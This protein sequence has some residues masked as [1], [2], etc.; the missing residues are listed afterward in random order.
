MNELIISALYTYPIKSCHGISLTSTKIEARGLLH[1]RRWMLIDQNNR[2]ISQRE[3]A[4]LSRFLLNINDHSLIVT[5]NEEQKI[6][7][8]LS[9]EEINSNSGELVKIWDDTCP[10]IAYNEDINNWF[11]Q[12]IGKPCRL[13]YMPDSSM[14]QVDL[15]YASAGQI[16]AFSDGYPILILGQESMNNLNSLLSTPIS[17]NRFRPNIVFT[18][19]FPHVED[20]FQKIRINN[21][22]LECVKPSRRCNVPNINQETSI[23]GDEPTKTLAGYRLFDKRILFG[24][25]TLVHSHGLIS[26][27]DRIQVG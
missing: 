1:D 7:P 13:V 24:N 11:S 8:F 25:N 15:E 19:G 9:E 27:D 10:A 20:T 5:F 3:E 2:F 22:Q 17:I 23:A 26:V 6:I 16:T 18:G 4:I 21:V 12:I 14:R